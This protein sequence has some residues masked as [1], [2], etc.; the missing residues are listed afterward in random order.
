MSTE[1]KMLDALKA[2]AEKHGW[3]VEDLNG[4]RNTPDKI[5]VTLD[6]RRKEP[7]DG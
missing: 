2:A 7:C 1:A 3:K 5:S 6:L 4:T